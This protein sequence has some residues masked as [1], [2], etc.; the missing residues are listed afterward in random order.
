MM[1]S[2][3]SFVCLPLTTSLPLFP[4]MLLSITSILMLL[5]IEMTT[6]QNLIIFIVISLSNLNVTK[7][8]VIHNFSDTT[9]LYK[10][11]K[12]K[13]N[14]NVNLPENAFLQFF[15]KLAVQFSLKNNLTNKIEYL[16][17]MVHFYV[18]ITLIFV[19]LKLMMIIRKRQIK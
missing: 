10:I 18:L 5:F 11:Y 13:T 2:L 17:V 6:F 1:F 15:D 9:S 7:H 16:P 14:N 12:E 3:L 4:F 8:F 19:V